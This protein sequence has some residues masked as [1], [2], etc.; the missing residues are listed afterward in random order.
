MATQFEFGDVRI[1]FVNGEK[2]ASRTGHISQLTFGYV[3]ELLKRDLQHLAASVE[4]ETLVI[5]PV[6]V[7]FDTMSDEKIARLSAAEIHR[8]VLHALNK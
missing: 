4:L 1:A 8:A 5:A 2:Y 3:E 6:E 7:S